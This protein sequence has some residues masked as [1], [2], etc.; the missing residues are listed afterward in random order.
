MLACLTQHGKGPCS[1]FRSCV[2]AEH[3]RTTARP[4]KLRNGLEEELIDL[5]AVEAELMDVEGL[6][7]ALTIIRRSPEWPKPR[8]V[9]AVTVLIDQIHDAVGRTRF[10]IDGHPEPYDE[11]HPA[12][13]SM[14]RLNA[15]AIA[16]L[17]DDE[18]NWLAEECKR[19][20]SLAERA[21]HSGE[22]A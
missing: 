14:S 13:L 22:A 5:H 10:A 20:L 17:P 8:A 19:V 9:N 6:R 1:Q 15:E 21:E 7:D 11:R 12:A 3:H 4:D 2:H 16:A 18:R